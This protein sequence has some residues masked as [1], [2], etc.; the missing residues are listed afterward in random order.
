VK[1]VNLLP[2]AL[3]LADQNG[4][5]IKTISSSG[6]ACVESIRGPVF[7]DDEIPVVLQERRMRDHVRGLPD[8]VE[9][10]YYVVN[11]FI[12]AICTDRDDLLV[13]GIGPKEDV[14]RIKGRN[15]RAIKTLIKIIK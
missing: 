8:P 2:Q 15:T 7:L 3:F 5:V 10:T 13:P 12:A 6:Y 11:P 9:G 14:A 4:V 1:L